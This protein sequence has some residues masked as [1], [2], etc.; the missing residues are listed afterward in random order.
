MRAVGLR[1][2]LPMTV[3][4]DAVRDVPS[5]DEVRRAVDRIVM[6]DVLSR[7]PQLAAFLRFV[8]EAVLHNRQDRIKAYTIG[9]E[10]LRR[11]TRLDP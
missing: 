5:P 2:D 6:S 4:S 9:V 11:D 1:S 8:V 7:S 3:D 10:V